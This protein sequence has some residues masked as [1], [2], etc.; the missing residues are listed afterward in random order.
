M[1]PEKLTGSVFAAVISTLESGGRKRQVPVKEAGVTF[2]EF[3]EVLA[4]VAIKAFQQP[5]GSFSQRFQKLLVQMHLHLDDRL[6][7]TS[8]VPVPIANHESFSLT[9]PPGVEVGFG[10][11]EANLTKA[12][13]SVLEDIKAEDRRGRVLNAF[14]HT[15]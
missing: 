12:E 9:S 6:L 13:Q 5:G 7:K 11:M 14:L 8:A 3:L 1:I 10:D 15:A 4:S 2:S